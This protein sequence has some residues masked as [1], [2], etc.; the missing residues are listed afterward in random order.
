MSVST[1]PHV[2]LRDRRG[3]T[4]VEV[5]VSLG[6]VG[7]NVVGWMACL[8]V[9]IVLA[10]RLVELSGDDGSTGALL[11]AIAAVVG[12]P[13]GVRAQCDSSRERH[14]SSGVTLV[15]LLIAVAVGSVV[16]GLLIVWNIGSL[17]LVQAVGGRADAISTRTALET[18]LT[19]EVAAAGRSVGEGMCGLGVRDGGRQIVVR[20]GSGADMVTDLLF[21][22]VDTGG[23]PAL[24][25]RRIPHPRQP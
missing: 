3:L 20:T 24:F 5:L 1:G 12:R 10:R 23:R 25:I 13:T 2:S 16:V 17:R 15:E 11:C 19:T 21:A 8:N 6:I 14:H 4:L 22:T 7:L 9:A 18:M